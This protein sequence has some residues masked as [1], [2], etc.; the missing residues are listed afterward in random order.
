MRESVSRSN[1]KLKTANTKL[2]LVL[3]LGLLALVVYFIANNYFATLQK[4]KEEVLHRLMA[5][6]RTAA[7]FVD[8]DAHQRL[9]NQYMVKDAITRSDQEQAYLQL[10]LLLA[11][12]KNEN[13]LETPLYTIVYYDRDSTFHF[14]G[15]SSE[16]PYFRHSYKN[17]PKELLT[18]HETGGIL[19]SYKDEN[20]HWLSAFS[21]IKNSKGEVVGLLEADENFEM[22][23]ARAKSKLL[24]NSLI[25]LAIVFPF[26]LLLFSFF[27]RSL[28]KQAEDQSMLLSQKEEIESQNEEIISQNELIEKQNRDLDQRVKDRTKE[29]E[30]TN[31]ELA[32]FLYHSSHDVQAP[33]ATLKGLHAL[34]SQEVKD[35]STKKYIAL[36]GETTRKLERMLK[37]IKLVHEIK[38]ISPTNQ[39][40]NLRECVQESI[41]SAVNGCPKPQELITVPAHL[42]VHVD[43]TL[44]Q[45]TLHEL[46][47]NA[48]Q[49]GDADKNVHLKVDVFQEGNQINLVIEDNGK[50]ISPEARKKLF[51][52]FTRGHEKSTGI[53]LGLYIAQECMQR[54]NGKIELQSKEGEG[55][56]FLVSFPSR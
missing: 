13:Q 16:I 8:G 1:L 4:S 17:Y 32:D 15:T 9:S 14:I 48:M 23:L 43:K 50:G 5:I 54:L 20:G 34:A 2:L 7:L 12:I 29:L 35:D 19:D 41:R 47:K 44:L 10:H 25:S 33:I 6:S 27:S 30:D 51:T 3:S 37:T 49:Y 46:F 45:A 31:A 42:D 38:T 28:K 11:K 52:M 53:G 22:F 40:I 55:A 36:M 21:P 18:Q 56:K 26:G 24:V 39:K